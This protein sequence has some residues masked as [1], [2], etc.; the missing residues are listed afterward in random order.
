M[1]FYDTSLL[2]IQKINLEAKNVQK[3]QFSL[4]LLGIKQVSLRKRYH[5]G[6]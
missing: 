4:V 6:W 2:T 5:N 3:D 1:V